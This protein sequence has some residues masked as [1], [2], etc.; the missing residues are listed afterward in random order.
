MP[1]GRDSMGGGLR[2]AVKAP[3]RGE[4]H[5]EEDLEGSAREGDGRGPQGPVWARLG[6]GEAASGR[7]HSHAR[8]PHLCCAAVSAVSARPRRAP[9]HKCPEMLPETQPFSSSPLI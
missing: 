5:Q 8:R 9:H 4:T 6:W 2:Q 3:V 1:R 7:P